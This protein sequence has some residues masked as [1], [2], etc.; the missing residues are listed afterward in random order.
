MVEA[1]SDKAATR[2]HPSYVW[3]AGQERRFQMVR[4]WAPLTG[5]RVLDVGCGIGMYTAAFLRETLHVFGIDV[6]LPT[7]GKSNDRD[8]PRPDPLPH[9]PKGESKVFSGL[10]QG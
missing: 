1:M 4:R 3:R 7:S 6:H 9:R 5:Q 10:S 2:G 8:L